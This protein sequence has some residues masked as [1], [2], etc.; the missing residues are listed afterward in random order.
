MSKT[1]EKLFKTRHRCK[2]MEGILDKLRF[3]GGKIMLLSSHYKIS[4]KLLLLSTF[5]VPD[6]K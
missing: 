3:I 6:K 2:G 1:P 4:S 5:H